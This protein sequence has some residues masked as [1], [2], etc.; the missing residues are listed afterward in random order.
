MYLILTHQR[1][2]QLVTDNTCIHLLSLTSTWL[3]M[4]FTWERITLELGNK[5]QCVLGW[6]PWQWGKEQPFASLCVQCLYLYLTPK[7][8]TSEGLAKPCQQRRFHQVPL[9]AQWPSEQR[10]KWCRFLVVGG[11][12]S[13]PYSSL[14]STGNLAKAMA[15]LLVECEL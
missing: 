3:S 7:S 5:K 8:W 11:L 13:M 1:W 15:I 2:I 12:F 10:G 9:G 4:D 14:Q 6:L